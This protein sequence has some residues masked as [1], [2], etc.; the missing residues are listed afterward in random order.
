MKSHSDVARPSEKRCPACGAELQRFT[1]RLHCPACNKDV[2]LTSNERPLRVHYRADEDLK[3]ERDLNAWQSAEIERMQKALRQIVGC[4]DRT[5][6]PTEALEYKIARRALEGTPAHETGEPR[7]TAIVEARSLIARLERIERHPGW[8]ERARNWLA[9]PAHAQKAS[10][11]P[12]DVPAREE[13]ETWDEYRKRLQLFGIDVPPSNGSEQSL[14][15][16]VSESQR[17]VAELGNACIPP[18][19]EPA[20]SEGEV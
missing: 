6:E 7:A 10:E 5:E 19:D 18:D 12:F 2:T 14:T 1:S 16:Y 15:S 3:F 11:P 20:E 9:T 17:R 13:F 8:R 4:W